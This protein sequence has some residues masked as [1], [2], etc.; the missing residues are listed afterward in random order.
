MSEDAIEAWF[1]VAFF[2]CMLLGHTYLVYLAWFDPDRLEAWTKSTNIG[3]AS[4]ETIRF[5]VG[6]AGCLWPLF[7]LILLGIGIIFIRRAIYLTY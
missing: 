2:I 4:E 7:W 5:R 1:G 3:G 6:L